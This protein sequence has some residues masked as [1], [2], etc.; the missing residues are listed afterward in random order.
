MFVYS[1]QFTLWSCGKRRNVFLQ[2]S[3]SLCKFGA[4]MNNWRFLSSFMRIFILFL[5]Q[6]FA[7]NTDGTTIN[8]QYFSMPV[9]ARYVRL[10]N[11][12]GS[13]SVFNRFPCM[14]VEVYGCNTP[15]TPATVTTV[16]LAS[17]TATL[18]PS[19]TIRSMTAMESTSATG[20]SRTTLMPVAVDT[21]NLLPVGSRTSKHS[22]VS[23]TLARHSFL[24]LSHSLWI[25]SSNS[26]LLI[27]NPTCV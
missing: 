10:F 15:T 2:K 12:T 18:S 25:V 8:K 3:H 20:T 5:Q 17:T 16:T 9:R 22:S 13:K 6:V 23:R 19:S 1:Y 26:L 21:T 14:R 27:E 11:F 7:A 4:N 24:Y